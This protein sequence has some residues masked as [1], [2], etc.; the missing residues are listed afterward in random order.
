LL[1]KIEEKEKQIDELI[2]NMKQSDKQAINNMRLMF[3]EKDLQKQKLIAQLETELKD[4]VENSNYDDVI[5]SL[6][7]KIKKLK[8]RIEELEEINQELEDNLDEKE[9]N[10]DNNNVDS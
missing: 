9:K 3:E 7:S 5:N 10:D 2:S 1:E 4:F 6:N 8:S